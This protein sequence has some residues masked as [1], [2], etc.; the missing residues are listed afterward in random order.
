MGSGHHGIPLT[1]KKLCCL[2]VLE[3]GLVAVDEEWHLT[4]DGY[5]LHTV[6]GLGAALTAARNQRFDVIAFLHEREQAAEA[7]IVKAA[8]ARNSEVETLCLERSGSANAKLALEASLRRLSATREARRAEAR[9]QELLEG[10]FDG[11]L[12]VDPGRGVVSA[13][14]PAAAGVLGYTPEEMRGLTVEQVIGSGGASGASRELERISAE[15]VADSDAVVLRRRNGDVLYCQCK[16]TLNR[17]PPNGSFQIVFRQADER[18]DSACHPTETEEPLP[19]DEVVS[20]FVHEINN[21][22]AALSGYAQLS[23]TTSSRQKLDEYLQIICQQVERC[24]VIV[25]ALSSVAKRPHCAR[26]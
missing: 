17:E 12:L 24:R 22:L 10:V 4:E 23:L 16:V 25:E 2:I 26:T 21:P 18:S 8:R 6:A 13:A 3:E 20:Q 5:R 15:G 1:D 7:E 11:V 9:F 14:N 19:F